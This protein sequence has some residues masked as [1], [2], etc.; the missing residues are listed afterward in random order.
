MAAITNSDHCAFH[1]LRTGRGLGSVLLDRRYTAGL[2]AALSDVRQQPA[3]YDAR[4]ARRRGFEPEHMVAWPATVRSVGRELAQESPF[5]CER[6]ALRSP[7]V[8][9]RLWVVCDLWTQ[10]AK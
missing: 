6:G 5:G 7:L 4:A 10:G 3:A 1:I 2:R 8:A 9:D